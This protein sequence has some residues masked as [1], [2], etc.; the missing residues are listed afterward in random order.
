MLGSGTALVA[1]SVPVGEDSRVLHCVADGVVGLRSSDV[2]DVSAGSV[3]QS[4]RFSDLSLLA[5]AM[6]VVLTTLVS[7]TG[8]AVAAIVVGLLW[9]GVVAVWS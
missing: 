5:K 7:V 6:V 8:L 9:R 3:R 4:V 1:G 2:G